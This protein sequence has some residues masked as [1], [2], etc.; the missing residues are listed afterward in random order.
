M[1]ES[2]KKLANS[3]CT[4][5]LERIYHGD[6]EG[7]EF[8]GE[9]GSEERGEMNR[10]VRKEDAKGAKRYAFF[11]ASPAKSWSSFHQVN[12]GSDK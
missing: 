9:K 6:T 7:T 1:L 3:G 11:L 12:Q 2:Y 10:K 8:H 4:F 5:G